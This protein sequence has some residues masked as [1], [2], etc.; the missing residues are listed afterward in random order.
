MAKKNGYKGEK[1]TI[2]TKIEDIE[3]RAD[4]FPGTGDIAEVLKD[5]DKLIKRQQKQINSL[6]NK[7]KS[8]DTRESRR[9]VVFGQG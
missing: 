3:N 4:V 8:I 2:L 5:F 1:V 6:E 9:H 7:I